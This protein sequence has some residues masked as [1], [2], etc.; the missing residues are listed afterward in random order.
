MEQQELFGEALMPQ[1]RFQLNA[2]EKE[3]IACEFKQKFGIDVV[4]AKEK[5]GLNLMFVSRHLVKHF[6]ILIQSI[7]G[8]IIE[9]SEDRAYQ[10]LFVAG[11]AYLKKYGHSTLSVSDYLT[12]LPL[13]LSESQLSAIVKR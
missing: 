1:P 9:F 5:Y 4:A 13:I 11:M 12:K 10:N 6:I 2:L 3:L 7:K 8:C